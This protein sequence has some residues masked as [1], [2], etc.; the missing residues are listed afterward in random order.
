MDVSVLCWEGE[1]GVG[2][3]ERTQTGWTC[4]F[5]VLGGRKRGG[6]GRGETGWTCLFCVGRERGGRER[7]GVDVSVLCVGGGGGVGRGT[8]WTCLFCV[9]REGGGD[10]GVR[11]CVYGGGGGRM[12]GGDEEL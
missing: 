1:V 11:V 10:G 4:L 7:D 12:I 9:G 8:G 2:E 6:R 3:G 5:C